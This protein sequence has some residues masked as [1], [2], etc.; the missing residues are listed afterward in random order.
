M[1][2]R[3]KQLLFYKNRKLTQWKAYGSIKSV[4]KLNT[5]SRSSIILQHFFGEY[6]NSTVKALD[7]VADS[8]FNCELRSVSVACGYAQHRPRATGKPGMGM[9]SWT[10]REPVTHSILN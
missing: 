3:V 9:C 4:C 5:D 10:H 2:F 7:F 8:C 6:I 1:L